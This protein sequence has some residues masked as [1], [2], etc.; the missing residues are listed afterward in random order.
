[1]KPLFEAIPF[2]ILEKTEVTEDGQ[3][4]LR[5]RGVFHR[6]EERNANNRIYP[7]AII[8]RETQRMNDRVAKGAPVYMQADHPTDGASRIGD[9]TAILR[10]ATF[11]P[12]TNEVIGE[13]DIIATHKGKDLIEIIK[14]GGGIGVSARG[15]GTTKPGEYAGSKGDVVQEDYQL[16]TY[17]FVVGQSTRGAVVTNFLEQALSLAGLK[18]EEMDL[19]NLTLE[20][21]EAAN[22][23]L[24]KSLKEA[25]I[26]TAKKTVQAEITKGVEAGIAAKEKEVAEAAAKKKKDS[27]KDDEDDD[28]VADNNTNNNEQETPEAK[29]LKEEAAKLG[30]VLSKAPEKTAKLESEIADVR[31]ALTEVTDVVKTL[32][33]QQKTLVEQNQSL[34]VQKHINEKAKDEK[35]FKNPL[36]ERLM[37]DCKTIA[38]VDAKYE[39]TKA[40]ISRLLSEASG[41]GTT[42]KDE[43]RGTPTNANVGGEKTFKT[44]D[45]GVLTESQ[46]RTRALSGLQTDLLED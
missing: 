14:A 40:E 38:E 7:K 12:R 29:K 3:K 5:V 22:P 31:K 37:K 42:T 6:A 15:F 10:K 4:R 20:Q 2:E 21:L 25:A 43:E 9:T 45:F 8:E 24:A 32:T 11:D 44:K 46:L 36:I 1:M 33:E 41:G 16:V 27:K 34:A 30:F 17:D 19:K 18:G 28:Q 13:A 23:E 35:K 26:E 39:G